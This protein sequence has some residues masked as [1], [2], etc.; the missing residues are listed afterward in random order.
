G[1]NTAAISM[2]PRR[3]SHLDNNGEGSNDDFRAYEA[4]GWRVGYEVEMNGVGIVNDGDSDAGSDFPDTDPETDGD[5]DLDEDEVSCHAGY[6]TLPFQM[7]E[8]VAENSTSCDEGIDQNDISSSDGNNNADDEG[9]PIVGN[10]VSYPIR[11]E[12]EK[13]IQEKSTS[14]KIS[15]DEPLPHRPNSIILDEEKIRTIREAMSGF[16]LPPPPQW[17]N[18]DNDK[19]NQ[20]VKEKISLRK[21]E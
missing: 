5:L 19:F 12:F 2:T 3:E 18:L 8:R 14:S 16:T 20:I 11:K 13:L 4:D 9:P 15:Y 17:A 1:L 21:P 6:R 7:E 10:A